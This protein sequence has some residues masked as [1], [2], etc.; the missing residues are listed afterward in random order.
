[1]TK[2]DET[3][4]YYL[5]DGFVHGFVREELL[6]V[7]PSTQLLPLVFSIIEYFINVCLHLPDGNGI[8]FAIG[9]GVYRIFCKKE[10]AI[11]GGGTM[12]PCSGAVH[13]YSGVLTAVHPYHGE[14]S[15]FRRGPSYT[16]CGVCVS[17]QHV[18]GYSSGCVFLLAS[19][20]PYILRYRLAYSAM[21][22]SVLVSVGLCVSWS[23]AEH[24]KT[25]S[26]MSPSGLL[27]GCPTMDPS[28][29]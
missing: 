6:A 27:A 5:Q 9:L 29:S 26:R 10:L 17:S 14:K 15:S 24:S 12:I 20:I 11:K 18:G 22:C 28:K 13:R 2:P 19:R 8:L 4:L 16:G 25:T 21:G 23:S 3:V 1:M 7:P